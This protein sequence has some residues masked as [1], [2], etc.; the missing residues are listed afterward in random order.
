[1]I[2]VNMKYLAFDKV[3]SIY[4]YTLLFIII[5]KSRSKLYYLH[6]Y[7][8]YSY[9]NLIS[10]SSRDEIHYYFYILSTHIIP[11]LYCIHIHIILFFVTRI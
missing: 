5:S 10:L 11:N 8:F 6:F 2:C 7:N 1:M 4:T 9:F 3:Y